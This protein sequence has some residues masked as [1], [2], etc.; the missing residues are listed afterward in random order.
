M[1]YVLYVHVI[2]VSIVIPGINVSK[3]YESLFQNK[4]VDYSFTSH[5]VREVSSKLNVPL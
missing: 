2:C 1:T 4:S 5:C 3:I